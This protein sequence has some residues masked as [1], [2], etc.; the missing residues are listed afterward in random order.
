MY[1]IRTLSKSKK[2]STEKYYTYRLI[3]STRIGKKVKKITLLNLGS[4]FNVEQEDWAELSTD[5]TQLS[6]PE[7]EKRHS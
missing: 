1:I 4:D 3:E 2:N 7:A 5:I 6:K